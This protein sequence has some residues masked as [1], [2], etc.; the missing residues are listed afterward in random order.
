MQDAL[1]SVQSVLVLGG[2]SD[3]A[4][5]TVRELV[6]RRARTIVLAARDPASLGAVADELRAAGGSGVNTVVETV[7]FDARDSA[8]HEAF[9]DDVFARFGDLDLA[10][11]TFGV[12][13]DQARA[14]HDASAA[15]DIAEVNYVGAVSVTVPLAQKMRAQG[16]GTI[17]VLSSVA[18]ERARRSNF[19][20][21][22][23]KAGLDTFFQG[24]GD[25]LVG[26]GVKVMVVRPGF[27]HTKMTKGMEPAPLSTTPEAVATAI[28]RGLERGTETVWVPATLRYVMS[29]LRHVPRPIFRRLPI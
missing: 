22:S 17:A 10:L 19:V 21:G 26:T 8:S 25:S 29:A 18:G 16:H 5:A 28:V 12:L 13:G 4:Q 20:Y 24:L 3:I 14:E 6:R 11:L 7:A 15:V 9:I 2:G 1:G 23:S 27:V